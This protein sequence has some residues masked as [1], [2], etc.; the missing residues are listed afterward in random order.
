MDIKIGVLPREGS[1]SM[2]NQPE[3]SAIEAVLDGASS[4]TDTVFYYGEAPGASRL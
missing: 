1:C 2:A 3:L 4:Q